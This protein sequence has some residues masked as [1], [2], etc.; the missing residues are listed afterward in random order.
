MRVALKV[1]WR[2]DDDEESTVTEEQQQ[3]SWYLH[4]L[5]SSCFSFVYT[6][7]HKSWYLYSWT[8]FTFF[9]VYSR[10]FLVYSYI[11][12]HYITHP[13]F[14]HPLSFVTANN[15]SSIHSACHF[16]RGTQTKNDSCTALAKS[17]FDQ[18]GENS[19]QADMRVIL[20]TAYGGVCV[21]KCMSLRTSHRNAGYFDA[22]FHTHHALCFNS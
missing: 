7:T 17:F 2:L 6:Q 13:S 5:L 12:F 18:R 4:N 11:P 9:L 16:L 22:R 20:M 19:N 10:V 21:S 15:M 8:Q 14:W 1:H 3:L